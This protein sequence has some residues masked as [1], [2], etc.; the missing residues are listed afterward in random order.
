MKVCVDIQS[1]VTQRAGVGRYTRTLVHHLGAA[2]GANRLELFYFDFK[3]RGAA[4]DAPG[5]THRAVRWCPGAAAQ[6]CWKY[7]GWPP[8]ECFAGK[9][10]LYHFPNFILP[11]LREARAVVTIHDASFIRFPEFAE[12]KNLA[13]LSARIRDTVHRARAV[14]TISRFSAS[15]ICNLLDVEP[16]RVFSVYPGISPEFRRPGEERIRNDLAALGIANA[17]YLLTVGTLEPRKNI[18]LAIETFERMPWFHGQ[19]VIAGMKGWKCEPILDRM[20]NSP[21][22]ASIRHLDHVCDDRLPSL[23]AGAALFLFPS[24]YEGFGFPPLESMA[25]GTP[26][27]S[28]S[29]GSLPEVLGRGAAVLDSMDPGRWAAEAER[30]ITDPVVRN[31]LLQQGRNQ[32]ASYNWAETARQTWDVYRR[33]AGGEAAR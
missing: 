23:Y 12:K 3:R 19:L 31:A 30:I 32:A 18:P 16:E 33:V 2:A 22:A 13:Y 6:A 9:A 7:A 29:G 11:P 20:R 24:F 27:L 17:P 26:V 5:A 14:L 28:S 1:A 4:F 10:D 25:C 8:F 15:E 21:R